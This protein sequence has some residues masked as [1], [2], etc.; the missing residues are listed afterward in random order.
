MVITCFYYSALCFFPLILIEKN[1]K[2]C[3][4]THSIM[5]LPCV[6][7]HFGAYP[8]GSYTDSVDSKHLFSARNLASEMPVLQSSER[9]DS[10]EPGQ[11]VCLVTAC[12]CHSSAV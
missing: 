4:S 8:W 3:A 12:E 7:V 1:D 10:M 11:A 6:A 9:R 2:V 5:K